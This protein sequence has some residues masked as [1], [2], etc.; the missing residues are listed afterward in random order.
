VLV[1][2][3]IQATPGSSEAAYSRYAL[4]SPLDRKSS[5]A[6]SPKRLMR[7]PENVVDIF[8]IAGDSVKNVDVFIIASALS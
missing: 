3:G 7:S 5:N 2:V 8:I 4:V 6:I 1:I